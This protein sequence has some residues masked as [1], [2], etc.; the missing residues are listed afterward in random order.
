MPMILSSP[1][2]DGYDTLLGERGATLSGGQRQRI[3]IAR[4][5]LRSPRL[6]I[7]DEA[8]SAL[9]AESELLVQEALSRLMAG[10][11]TFVIASSAFYHPQCPQDTGL[12]RGQNRGERVARRTDGQR[13]LYRRLYEAQF[14]KEDR[15]MST[16]GK[17]LLN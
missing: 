13:R 10:R 16:A 12:G 11:T 8:T 9:D 6:L 17:S 14:L 2:P 1:L 5:V 3:A 4:A 15:E 7:L